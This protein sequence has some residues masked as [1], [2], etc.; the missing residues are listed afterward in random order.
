M[1]SMGSTDHHENVTNGHVDTDKDPE[2]LSVIILEEFHKLGAISEADNIKLKLL[3]YEQA[4]VRKFEEK[5]QI[6]NQLKQSLVDLTEKRFRALNNNNPLDKNVNNKD[7]TLNNNLQFVLGEKD[8]K[9][10]KLV[11]DIDEF[12]KEINNLKS[13]I[14]DQDNVILSHNNNIYVS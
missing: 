11:A 8:I 13:V 6:I 7:P 9:I 12:H 5:E 10:N 14:K 1:I 2:S 3:E 4:N